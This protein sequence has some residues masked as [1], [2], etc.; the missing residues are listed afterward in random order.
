MDYLLEIGGI[1]YGVTLIAITFIR[2]KYLEA[3][4]LDALLMPKP[5]EKTR[6]INLVAGIAFAGYSLYSIFFG[7]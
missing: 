5:T 4:R 1:I 7:I 2:N 6:V 3:F